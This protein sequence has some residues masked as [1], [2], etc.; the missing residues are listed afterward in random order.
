MSNKDKLDEFYNAMKERGYTVKL[1]PLSVDSIVYRLS[2]IVTSENYYHY[3]IDERTILDAPIDYLI[4]LIEKE[5][6]QL[7]DSE[8]EVHMRQ[9]EKI[10]IALDEVRKFSNSYRDMPIR[11]KMNKD[12]YDLLVKESKHKTNPSNR[13]DSIFGLSFDIDNTVKTYEFIYRE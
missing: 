13:Y 7:K 10:E 11:I 12:Y 2:H 4:N 6:K 5:F 3:V 9:I 8:S 1:Y